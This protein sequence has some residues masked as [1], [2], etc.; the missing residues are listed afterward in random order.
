[1]C[2]QPTKRVSSSSNGVSLLLFLT[3]LLRTWFLT[4]VPRGWFNIKENGGTCVEILAH[5]SNKACFKVF[6]AAAEMPPM[7]DIEL[8]DKHAA[9]PKRFRDTP[10]TAASIGLYF[11]PACERW[12][13][14]EFG[15]HSFPYSTD[16][17]VTIGMKEFMIVWWKSLLREIKPLKLGL[18]MPNSWCFHHLNCHCIAGVSWHLTAGIFKIE[19]ERARSHHV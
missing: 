11:F 2:L 16:W 8:L 13:L 15:M 3:I 14:L 19:R 9:L 18:M 5:L 6:N 7:L 10:P 17:L 1:M 4:F 12:F